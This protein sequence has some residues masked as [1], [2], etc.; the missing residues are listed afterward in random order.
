MKKLLNFKEVRQKLGNRSRSAIYVDV[1]KGR[2]PQPIKLGEGE[3]A[4][5]YWYEAEIEAHLHR[6]HDGVPQ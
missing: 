1:A 3:K 4:K 2:I 6:L 5:L